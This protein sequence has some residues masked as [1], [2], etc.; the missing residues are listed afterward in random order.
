MVSCDWEE[1][2]LRAFQAISFVNQTDCCSHVWSQC[3]VLVY[4]ASRLLQ[5]KE[6]LANCQTEFQQ[7]NWSINDRSKSFHN[8]LVGK[9]CWWLHADCTKL[10]SI[11]SYSKIG[12]WLFSEVEYKPNLPKNVWLYVM[13]QSNDP[14]TEQWA[15]YWPIFTPAPVTFGQL[16]TYTQNADR[17]GQTFVN[18][19][20]NVLTYYSIQLINNIWLALMMNN[21]KMENVLF[22]TISSE[23]KKLYP[24]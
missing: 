22:Y 11:G 3:S 19:V 7:T 12:N 9:G 20:Q 14:S 18:Y 21:Y 16:H 15:P 8:L 1:C 13:G 4:K 10:N 17:P 5:D 2:H 23:S 24:Q 6:N